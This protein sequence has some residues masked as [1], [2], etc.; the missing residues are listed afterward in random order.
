MTTALLTDRYELTMLGSALR[1][2]TAQRRC[3]FEVFARRLPDGRR[4]GVVAGTG[5]VLEAL[6]EFRFD[7][8]TV[9]GLRAAEVIDDV[10]A[11]YLRG[12]RFTGDID[13]MAE[14]TVFFADEPILRVSAP[15]R[16]AQLIE[17]RIMNLMHYQTLVA[18]K[19]VRSV[20]AAPGYL[21]VDFGLRRAHGAEA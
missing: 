17:S 21:L 1:D 4:Y 3:T 15:L 16:E 13:A 19:A 9:E 18:S 12:Y 6:A 7:D 14:G 8:G 5:R 11:D 10:T 20:L 2:G